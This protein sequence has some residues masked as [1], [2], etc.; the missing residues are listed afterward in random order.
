MKKD[1]TLLILAAGMG[2][3]YGSLK[4]MDAFGPHGETIIDYSIYDAIEA[5][6]TKIVF[7][8]RAHFHEKIEKLFKERIGDRIEMVF[9]DQELKNLPEGFKLNPEREKP[10][11]TAHAVLVAKDVINE[12]FAIIN[13]DDYYGKESYKTVNNFLTQNDD[14]SHYTVIS[15]LLK[16]T[17]SEHGSVNRGICMS[18]ENQNL[19][20]IVETL[21]IFKNEDGSGRYTLNEKEQYLDQNTLVSM[22]M[23]GFYP[24]YFKYVND[25]FKTFLRNEGD[26][27]KSE[28]FIPFVL[29]QMIKDKLINVKVLTSP[30]TWFG[31]TYKEDKPIVMG[32]IQSLID[33]GVYPEKLW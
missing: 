10:W 25:Y 12:P 11:G 29:D 7:I 33:Q 28:F 1:T 15:Y 31:V 18:D 16:N 23:F 2:S 4:Q 22:N 19:T 9:V 8:V 6:F 20:K 26:K 5:G 30:S 32:K 24:N 3:R 14:D 17:L 21:K 27:L 13:A